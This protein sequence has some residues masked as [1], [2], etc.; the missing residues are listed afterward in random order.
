MASSVRR[1]LLALCSVVALTL[2]LAAAP[3]TAAPPEERSTGEVPEITTPE[4]EW[5]NQDIWVTSKVDS[6]NDG[7]PDRIHATVTRPPD[8]DLGDTKLSTVYEVS[9]YYAG[10]NPVENHNVDHELYAPTRPGKGWP[11]KDGKRRSGTRTDVTGLMTAEQQR[12]AAGGPQ[13]AIGRLERRWVPRGYAVIKAESI[14]SGQSEGCP[15]TGDPAETAGA[16][17]VIDWLNGRAEAVDADGDPVEADWSTGKAGM[18]GTSYNGTLP[19]AVAATGIDGLEAIIPVSAISS[20]YGYYREDGLVVAPGGY[21]GEDA[22]VLAKYVYTREDQQICRPVIDGLT[23]DQDRR[24]GDYSAFWDARNYLDDADQVQAAVLVAHG[25]QDWNV[26]PSQAAEWY[27]ALQ[28]AGAESMIYWHQGGHGGEPPLDLQER[29]FAHYLYGV[30]NGVEDEPRALIQREDGS[31][32]TY[33]QWPDPAMREV[34]MSLAP[35]GDARTGRLVEAKATGRPVVE[36]FT[37]TPT[38]TPDEL[39]A[40][41]DPKRGLV[42]TTS[43][44]SEDTRLS[45]TATADLRMRFSRPAGNVTVGLVDLAPDGSVTRLV[46]EGWTDPQNRRSIEETQIVKPGTFYRLDLNLQAN[47][48]VFAKGHRIGVVVMSTDEAFTIRPSAGNRVGL[49]VRKST[50]TLPLVR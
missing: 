32:R 39:A 22:D 49:D 28:A 47:D 29:W 20:W 44:L 30:D 36:T 41:P 40:R 10:G 2:S 5:V 37:D 33:A 16:A 38:L 17:A 11:G 27:Q 6:D 46:T 19:N 25:L 50:V 35:R 42:Y 18:I 7:S 15:T 12:L 31:L 9:P 48:Y 13:P 4:S 34:E 21:Q 23:R 45:G 43:A 24:T 26:K 1:S 3:G 8:S 14:G